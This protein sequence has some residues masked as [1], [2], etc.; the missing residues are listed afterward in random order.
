MGPTSMPRLF[1][2]CPKC[3]LI[4]LDT[5]GVPAHVD[6]RAPVSTAQVGTPQFSLCAGSG[7]VAPPR[8]NVYLFPSVR[9]L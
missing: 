2:R 9:Y 8:S 3:G 4:F 7:T 5:T 6:A 1:T